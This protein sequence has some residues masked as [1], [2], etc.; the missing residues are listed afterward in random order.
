MNQHKAYQALKHNLLPMACYN[1]I[2]SAKKELVTLP[3]LMIARLITAI[4]SLATDPRPNGVRKLTGTQDMYR[5]RVADYRIVYRIEDDRLVIEVVR[6][7]HRKE[8][9]Q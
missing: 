6:V 4:E 3:K 5:V 7:A 1:V 8:V 9:Y 2:T